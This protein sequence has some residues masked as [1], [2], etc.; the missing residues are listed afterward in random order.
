M[1][2]PACLKEGFSTAKQY[3]RH[4]WP[5]GGILTLNDQATVRC[6]NC[7]REG[8]LLNMILKCEED[9][10]GFRIASIEGYAMAISTSA[11][12]VNGA[13]IAWLQSVLKFL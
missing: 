12:F 8:H 3:W 11:H 4:S 1:S 5:C 2:C 9:R 10:H 7:G 13:G 6:S